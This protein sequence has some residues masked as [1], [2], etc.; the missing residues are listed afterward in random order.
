[1]SQ[2]EIQHIPLSQI[3]VIPE[4]QMRAE[5]VDWAF[6]ETLAESIK[7]GAQLPPIHLFVTDDPVDPAYYIGNGNHRYHGHVVAELEEINAI[8]EP[9][10]YEAAFKHALGA[11]AEQN[12]K[13][14]TRKDIRKAVIA[15]IEELI[16]N[17]GTGQRATQQ[18][19]AE[20]CKCTQK[21]VSNI[22]REL[23]STEVKPPKEEEQLNFFDH[24]NADFGIIPETFKDLLARPYWV[25][26]Q[27]SA[28]ERLQGMAL[29]R[30]AG[31]V[32]KDGTP[33]S[34]SDLTNTDLTK[35]L[36]SFWQYTCLP[37]NQLEAQ[38]RQTGAYQDSIM[39]RYSCHQVIDLIREIAPGEISEA[40]QDAWLDGIF[41]QQ[42]GGRRLGGPNPKTGTADQWHNV[43]LSCCYRY[44]QV[45]R[46]LLG[47]PGVRYDTKRYWPHNHQANLELLQAEGVLVTPPTMGFVSRPDPA[48]AP[49]EGQPF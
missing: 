44:D 31:V 34:S 35:V 3:K 14:R 18:E 23:T 29:H 49:R 9:G 20:L 10:G 19:I 38:L 17:V 40:G 7:D 4:L 2:P 1:M 11:N 39:G 41:H 15:A 5:D 43:F 47:K 46:R 32:Y 37:A 26:E 16:F 33:K 27:Y 13:P 6:V 21:T 28:K 45:M 42:T 25:D 30:R 22:F 36:A 24:L 12:A 48:Y 8:V